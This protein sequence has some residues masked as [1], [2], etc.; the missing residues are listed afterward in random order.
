M[1]KLCN[2]KS[3]NKFFIPQKAGV[4]DP[5]CRPGFLLPVCYIKKLWFGRWQIDYYDELYETEGFG[6]KR[7][8]TPNTRLILYPSS[9]QQ[10]RYI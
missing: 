4:Q 10:I 7:N 9:I 6:N 2:I 5:E 1:K 3:G 8:Q